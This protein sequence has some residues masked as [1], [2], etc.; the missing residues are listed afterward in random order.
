MKRKQ[1]SIED[2]DY[3]MEKVSLNMDTQMIIQIDEIADKKGISRSAMIRQ[4][5]GLWL[6]VYVKNEKD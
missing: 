6:S 2:V 1:L 3:S 4:A 5:L